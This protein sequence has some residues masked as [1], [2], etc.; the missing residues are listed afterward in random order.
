MQK[1]TE[2]RRWAMIIKIVRILPFL[3]SLFLFPV[4][5]FISQHCHS[6]HDRG[7]LERHEPLEFQV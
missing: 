3:R 5:W 2:R 7:D 4:L 1:T 6:T